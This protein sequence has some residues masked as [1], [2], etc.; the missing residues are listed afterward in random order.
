MSAGPVLQSP[1]A[2]HGLQAAQIAELG[3]V[4]IIGAAVVF[5]VVLV[6][7]VWALGP[8]RPRWMHNRAFIIGGGLVFPL[9]VLAALFAYS[10]RVGDSLA[11]NEPASLRLAIVGEM[12]WWRVHYLDPHGEVDFATANEIHLPVDRT[13]EISLTSADVIHSFWL[14]GLS[15]MLDMIPGRVNTL[16]VSPLT[17]GTLRG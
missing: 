4:L 15:G 9:A 14:P 8:R 10:L 12:W 16:R 6:L 5:L 2:P 17:P 7:A 13:V 1:L 11:D 3:A